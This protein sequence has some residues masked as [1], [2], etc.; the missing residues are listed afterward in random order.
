[1]TNLVSVIVPC[2]NRATLLRQAIASCALQTHR[3]LEVIV[4]DDGSEE[5][6]R[7]A[8]E[9]ARQEHGFGEELR[10]VRQERR[11]G[12]SARNLGFG[13]AL[14][15]FVQYLD[16]DDLL[17]PDKL[18][19]QVAQ[20]TE[21]PELDMVFGLDEQ[22]AETVGD[23]RLL[24]NIP[25]RSDVSEHLDRFLTEDTVWQTGSPLWRKA[26]LQRIGPWD[27][28]LSCWQDWDFHV[29]AL[30]AGLRCECSGQ[31]LQYIRLHDGPRAQTVPALKREQDCF[32]A[33]NNAYGHLSR[34]GLLDDAKRTLLLRY[35]VKHLIGMG[36][37]DGPEALRLRQDML[38][39]MQ[40]LAPTRKRR[41]AIRAL[42][43]LART[44]LFG[45]ALNAYLGQTSYELRTQSLRNVVHAGFLPPPPEE[46]KNVVLNA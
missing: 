18:T 40:G 41:A 26:A 42:R 38:A 15:Q 31:V 10:Y 17:H 35:F 20:L 11:G 44:P 28:G 2:Y 13:H 1:M 39:F 34:N 19:V 29:R 25:V 7:Q 27:D 46:L 36:R 32:R 45:M 16:S 9:V 12:G 43:R 3:D 6:L 14:G 23:I 33:G 21:K 22:F 24:W 37:V 30:C 8:V 4:V 5:D